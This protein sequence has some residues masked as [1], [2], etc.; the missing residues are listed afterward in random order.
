MKLISLLCLALFISAALFAQW[1]DP[2]YPGES[3]AFQATHTTTARL[4]IRAGP[5]TDSPLVT[6]LEAGT[7]VQALETGPQAAIGGTIAPWVRVVTSD[8]YTGWCFSGF[9]T[10]V[11]AAPAIPPIELAPGVVPLLL[12][13][14]GVLP[15]A[16]PVAVS[17]LPPAVPA[18]AN[19]PPP[20]EAENGTLLT[21]L[22]W[23]WI[24]LA[25]GV[26]IGAAGMAAAMSR[27]KA[28]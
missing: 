28:K 9:L 16:A 7:S 4:N 25:G 17:A 2:S 5:S 19:V 11:A 27:R 20:P 12:A 3:L 13:G 10:A 6:T 1:D 22:P 21:G 24:A 8:G 18:A 15:P 26:L 14:P 23:V